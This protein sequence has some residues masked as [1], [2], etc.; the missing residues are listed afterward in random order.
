[1]MEA[2][3][4]LAAFLLVY[5]YFLYPALLKLFITPQDPTQQQ[6]EHW[7]SVDVILS[8]YNEESCIAERLTNLLQQDYP[9]L[10][11]IR[12]ASDGSSDKT[13]AIIQNFDDPRIQADVHL[14]NRGKVA[15][16]ND[17]VAQSEADILVFTDANTFFA[18]DAIRQLVSSFQ[19]QIGAVCGELHLQ[20]EDGNAN[21]DGLYWRYEQFL[22]E[23]E[24]SLGAL[25][26]ANGAIYAIRRALYQPLPAN[27]V[28]D[29][30]CIV[31]NIKR[32]GYDVVYN[33]KAKASEE[34]APSLQDEYGRRVRIG[35]GNYRAFRQHL[36][37]LS[38][39]KGALSWCY[40]SHKVLRWFG[41]HLMLLVLLS[42]LF[43]LASPWY[44]VTLLAQ[45]LF[46]GL[47][48]VGQ[49][50]IRQGHHTPSWLAI[51]SFFVS[52]NVA[53]AHGFLRYLQGNQQ[54][55]W[56]RTA[57]HGDAK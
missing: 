14:E 13:G 3:F 27:T 11:T 37:A 26:G 15:V 4:W 6:P 57:R 47:A 21:S 28:V 31:M 48:W 35:L 46:Y 56:K 38:P 53:L 5:S 55:A 24:S 51:L 19:Q 36:W 45:L 17:L 1:M 25:L 30:F 39:M 12:V 7:P 8:A 34:V 42:N 10:L 2:L 33:T 20:T 40:W 44:Q 32:Q 16:L 52:M 9:G 22:K 49:T 54:G 18:E 41:P 50:R 29:D 43:L 23:S